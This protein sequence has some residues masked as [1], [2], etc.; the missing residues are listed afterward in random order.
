MGIITSYLR[1]DNVDFDAVNQ[2]A[3]RYYPA[4]FAPGPLTERCAATN[5]RH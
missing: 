2:A 1:Q 4:W 3:L 5:G